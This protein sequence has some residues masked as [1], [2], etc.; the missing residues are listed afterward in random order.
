MT[1]NSSKYS[2]YQL[3]DFLLDPDF[4]SWVLHPTGELDEFWNA[5]INNHPTQYDTM[6]KAISI[7]KNLPTVDQ[8]IHIERKNILWDKIEQNLE[9]HHPKQTSTK[10]RILK[11][12]AALILI[13]GAASGIWFYRQTTSLVQIATGN[14]ESKS[15]RLPDGSNISLAPNSEISYHKDFVKNE[16]R[17]IWAK[18][19]AKFNVTHLNQNPR[20]VLKGERFIVHLDQEVNV[21]VL[22]TIFSVSSRQG[23]SLVELLSG[24]VRVK[25]NQKQFLLQPGESLTTNPKK[26]VVV[27]SKPLAITREWE[28]HTATLNRTSVQQIIVL[29]KNTYG[30]E[31]QV[32]NPSILAKE[33]DGVLPLDDRERALEIL[34]NITGTQLKIENGTYLLKAIR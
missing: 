21:E 1:K 28:Q 34:T 9:R 13:F 19:E 16:K 11:Y 3:F 7:I 25:Q 17:E 12:A 15:I 10:L 32:E 30:I 23:K 27:S 6:Q 22:G 31:L 5:V 14:G 8:N 2:T 4:K 18:G 26:E 29:I 20:T 33:L 24:S